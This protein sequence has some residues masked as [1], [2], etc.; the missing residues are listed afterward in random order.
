MPAF[1]AWGFSFDSIDGVAYILENMVDHCSPKTIR[2]I[3]L[4]S[5]LVKRGFKLLAISC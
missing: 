2:F 4:M 3:R 1:F 5:A